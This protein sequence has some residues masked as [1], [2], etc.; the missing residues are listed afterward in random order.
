MIDIEPTLE[1]RCALIEEISRRNRVRRDAQMHLINEDAELRRG[2]D[3]IRRK[4]FL[5]IFQPYLHHALDEHPR[6]TGRIERL[7]SYYRAERLAYQ[8]LVR[9]LGIGTRLPMK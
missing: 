8:R 7:V 5:A 1:E 2:M 6:G 3:A 9:D 4:K